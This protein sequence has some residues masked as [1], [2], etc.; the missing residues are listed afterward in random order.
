MFYIRLNCPYRINTLSSKLE[1]GLRPRD[2]KAVILKHRVKRRLFFNVETDIYYWL[3]LLGCV[4]LLGRF[5]G[6]FF[7][8]LGREGFDRGV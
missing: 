6:G 1:A 3:I 5:M 2:L 7:D 8:W 4:L